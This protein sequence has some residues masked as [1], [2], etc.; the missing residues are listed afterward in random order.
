MTAF[1]LA[2]AGLQGTS[3]RVNRHDRE[4]R[5]RRFDYYGE[6]HGLTDEEVNY[7]RE[8]WAEQERLR[9][10]AERLRAERRAS[11]QQKDL[12]W[13]ESYRQG[14]DPTNGRPLSRQQRRQ[15]ERTGRIPARPR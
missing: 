3:E 1:A 7:I 8:M 4:R 2:R 10:E 6:P 11:E 15:I 12:A 13:A 5:L 14:V 9:K